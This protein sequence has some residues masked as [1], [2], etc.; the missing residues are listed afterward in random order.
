MVSHWVSHGRLHWVMHLWLA[1][2]VALVRL[3]LIRME[4]GP[5]GELRRVS[6]RRCAVRIWL[7]APD[8]EVRCAGD[9]MGIWDVA[10]RRIGL[11]IGGP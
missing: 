2:C 9:I 4:G 6:I 5:M 11:V 1:G 7:P 3:A 8:H 10:W